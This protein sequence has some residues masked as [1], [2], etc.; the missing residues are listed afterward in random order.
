VGLCIR[1]GSRHMTSSMTN[2]TSHSSEWAASS[3]SAGGR[4]GLC[5]FLGLSTSPNL[6]HTVD[7]GPWR[8][9]MSP[10]LNHTVDCGLFNSS[11]AQLDTCPRRPFHHKPGTCSGPARA[12]IQLAGAAGGNQRTRH[13]CGLSVALPATAQE[14]CTAI[15]TPCVMWPCVCV[16]HMA[17]LRSHD[18]RGLHSLR[19]AGLRCWVLECTVGLALL[20]RSV[21][22][23]H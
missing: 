12:V 4:F 8:R 15:S 7:C 22:A 1:T 16:H 17:A 5:W 14:P 9:N 21:R 20:P 6:N 2:C 13:L 23:R 19:V 11:V 10:N 18:G 3:G